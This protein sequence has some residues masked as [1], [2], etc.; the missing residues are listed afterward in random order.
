MR[1][2]FTVVLSLFLLAGVVFASGQAAQQAGAAPSQQVVEFPRNE[3]LYSSGTMWAPPSNWN[4]YTPW[5]VATGTIGLCYEPLFLYDPLK[6]EFIP[7]LAESG[8]WVDAKTYEL[9]VRK[10]ITWQDGKPL[11]AEDVKFTFE[12]AKQQSVSLSTIWDWLAEIVK[13]DD[14]TLRFTFSDPRYQSWDNTLYT[15]GIVPKHIFEGKEDV[16]NDANENPVGSGAYKY[17]GH[18]EDRMIW[19]RNED[20]WAT[21]LLGKKVAPKYIVDIRN[22]SNNVA[23]GMVVKGELDLS[24][25]FLPGIAALVKQGYVK[26]YYDGPPYMLSANTAFLWLNLTKKP[27][28][29]PAFRRAI[30]FA[31]DTQKIVNVAYA[32]LVQASDP[33]GLLPTWSKYI[34]KNVVARYGFKYDTAQAKKILADA[35]YKDVDGDGFVEAPDGSKIRLSVIVPFGWTDWMESIKI[36]AEGCKA[37]GI[38]VEPEYPD[39]G[40]YSDQLYGG[41]FDM[42][43]NNFGS[44]LSNTPWT[45][46]N[47]VFYHP[48]SDN[49]PNGNFGR[50]NNQQIF[51]LVEQLNR[52]PTDDT[53][54]MKAVISKIQEIQLKEMVAIPLWF[55]GLWAQFNTSV[56]TNWP[57]AAPDTPDYMPCLWGGYVQVGG[58]LTLTELKPAQQ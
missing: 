1:K 34:D 28:N 41:T 11:T 13:V 7:W 21:K 9:K 32:G 4:P 40:G 18:S 50:Y 31:I 55:N 57:T 56:W 23:L 51:D 16:A 19:V 22:S 24:N 15:Q 38:N 14:Y 48:I 17:Y 45:F 37:A 44:G 42:A 26:T 6:D 36:V 2:A 46:Y 39:F 3:T 58:L 25:N 33:T 27:L 52:V 30:A 53:E 20:W 47:W 12:L 54:G 10:G 43:I 29:D 35:G 49:M 5:A 8:K